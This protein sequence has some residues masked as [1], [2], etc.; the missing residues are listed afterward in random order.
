M[1]TEHP[2]FSD[3][4]FNAPSNI[5]GVPGSRVDFGVANIHNHVTQMWND[6][7]D[8]TRAMIEEFAGRVDA[9]FEG[10]WWR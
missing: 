10:F 4:D 6:F 1:Y 5:R 3:F 8:A 9:T 7:A 2:G